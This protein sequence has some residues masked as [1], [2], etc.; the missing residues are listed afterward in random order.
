MRVWGQ[1]RTGKA[2]VERAPLV[3]QAV[4]SGLHVSNWVH[5][6]TSAEAG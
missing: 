2:K 4:F 6:A 1:V 3:F 5:C